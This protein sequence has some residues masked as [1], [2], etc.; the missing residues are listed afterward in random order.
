MA[1]ASRIA[2]VLFMLEPLRTK[3]GDGEGTTACSP[4]HG[5]A[6]GDEGPGGKPPGSGGR[7]GRS[8]VL[9]ALPAVCPITWA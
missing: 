2:T 4:A 5:R 7:A 8:P 1:A 6:V 3:K 9:D